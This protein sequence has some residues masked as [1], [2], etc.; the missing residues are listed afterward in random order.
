MSATLWIK[1]GKEAIECIVIGESK[2]VVDKNG[3]IQRTLKVRKIKSCPECT[4]DIKEDEIITIADILLP[5]P[6]DNIKREAV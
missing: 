6:N 2:T 1:R 3:D 4:F 5:S